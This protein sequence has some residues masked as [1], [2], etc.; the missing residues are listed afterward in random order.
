M[1]AVVVINSGGAGPSSISASGRTGNTSTIS[2][3]DGGPPRRRRPSADVGEPAPAGPPPDSLP[4][5]RRVAAAG[6]LVGAGPM[7]GSVRP[8]ALAERRGFTRSRRSARP[9]RSRAQPSRHRRSYLIAARL[10]ARGR[11]HEGISHAKLF[12]ERFMRRTHLVLINNPGPWTLSPGERHQPPP[13]CGGGGADEPDEDVLS[14]TCRRTVG[15]PP[16]CGGLRPLRLAR[17]T[18]DAGGSST[19]RASG[20]RS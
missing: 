1:A 8:W 17:S 9:F 4:P 20:G 14:S 3:S 6:S 5:C 15:Y 19:R 10:R 16:A 11:L 13:A 12:R 7:R 18:P 2:A